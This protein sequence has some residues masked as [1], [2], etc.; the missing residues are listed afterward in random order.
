MADD[1]QFHA[2][3]WH[4][5]D[6]EIE[7]DDDNDDENDNKEHN[8]FQ[9]VK[10]HLVIKT[11]G[12]NASGQ[13]V[14][15]TITGFNPYFYIRSVNPNVK[16]TVGRVLSEICKRVKKAKYEKPLVSLYPARDLMGFQGEKIHD[17]FKISCKEYGY[18]RKIASELA[19]SWS[20]VKIYESNVEPVL[21][22]CH[23][24]DINPAGW[25][26][27]PKGK[28]SRCQ[29]TGG[30]TTSKID[31][32]AVWKD[33]FPLACESVAPVSIASFDIEC[34]GGDEGDFPQAIKGYR[35]LAGQLIAENSQASLTGSKQSVFIRRCLQTAFLDPKDV[36]DPVPG[37]S[38]VFPK[39]TISSKAVQDLINLH[40][41]DIREII[42]QRM[43]VHVKEKR[44]APGIKKPAGYGDPLTDPCRYVLCGMSSG[45]QLKS[46]KDMTRTKEDILRDL[47]VKL[48]FSFPN[49][50]GDKI[51]Q[52]GTTF[53]AYGEQQVSRKHII[54]LNTCD[55]IEGVE[56]VQCETEKDLLLVWSDLIR[57]SDPDVL[58]GY[59]INGFDFAYMR[60][61]AVENNILEQFSKLGK[62]KGLSSNYC[63]ANLTSSALGEN[64]L[65]YFDIEGRVII[66]LM[67]VIQR[68]HKLDTYKL[69]DV[70]FTFLKER[71]NDVSP[72]DI[73]R[74]QLGD[75]ADRKKIAE[76]CVQ[77][78]ALCNRLLIRLETLANNL[79]MASVC[80]VPLQHIFRRGQ[81]IK[82][83]SLML[84]R[85]GAEKLLI[86][87][88]TP[89]P[90]EKYEGAV[91]LD[92]ETGMY[93]DEVVCVMDYNSLYPSSIIAENLSHDSIVLSPEFANLPDVEYNTVI[94][95][96]HTEEDGQKTIAGQRTCRFVKSIRGK[97]YKG[98]VP[99]IL[100]DLLAARKSTRKRATHRTI[101]LDDDTQYSG[102][103]KDHG[104]YYVVS[105]QS[106]E[107]SRV[108]KI[109]DVYDDFQKAV[110]DG[111][112]LAYKITANSI[113]GQMGARTSPVYLKDIAA[114]T[115]AVGRGM[116]HKAKAFMEERYQARV[117]YGDTDS[118]FCIFPSPAVEGTTDKE[119]LL[120]AMDLSDKATFEFNSTITHPQ[121][122]ESE[123]CFYPFCLVS[124]K[125]YIGMLYPQ[126]EPDN[127][128]MKSM[129]LV[130][131][132]RDNAPIVKQ[133][134]GGVIDTILK[135]RNLSKSVDFLDSCLK[136]LVTGEYPIEDLVITKS[137]KSTYADPLRIAHKVL[138]ERIGDRDPGNKPQSSDRIKY[139]FIESTAKL[140]GERIETP[141]FIKEQGLKVDYCFYI[142]NQ[143]MNPICQLYSIVLEQLIQQ[144]NAPH[145]QKEL[146]EACKKVKETYSDPSKAEDRIQTLQE[147]AVEKLLFTPIVKKTLMT[148]NQRMNNDAKHAFVTKW[149][150]KANSTASSSTAHQKMVFDMD[151]LSK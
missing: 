26:R 68:D 103:I 74:L 31:V 82:V 49:L 2:L 144:Q 151:S 120:H 116:I 114:C 55:D 22:F 147:R 86:P 35:K 148:R 111:L 60:D 80:V 42:N 41:D 47:D 127:G 89:G 112:Q 69:D 72:S 107:K 66:D 96:I 45:I 123:K 25:I 99:R 18:T 50:H 124:K 119:K 21:R 109:Q 130:L 32:Q 20:D 125:R 58:T 140:Q 108:T 77:D 128:K 100:E 126:G 14:S 62:I 59:N 146:N 67:K 135:E 75:S 30:F 36:K 134:Y 24:Q 17:F 97:P 40:S 43:Y 65:R 115:T 94:Y 110:L 38:K 4:A 133:I 105:G 56:V 8:Q 51:I 10:K 106:I 9:P 84:K 137:L 16:L 15:L 48:C 93:L 34:M 79:G 132:R 37:I 129:G 138:A 33:V 91:V 11:F 87:T 102:D 12:R 122:L 81:G 118:I 95:D 150:K 78:C 5:V 88:L 61:R 39:N 85:C 121:H 73:F 28:Y 7:E 53:H 145:V 6:V 143:I 90:P 142:T 76:Y 27:V 44:L 131:K 139:V 3:S 83:F 104:D 19:S 13:S 52:I 101:Y 98:I 23:E 136:R 1:L 54:T 46:A 29:G 63:E 57:T 141:E 64:L 149:Y 113:Y 71:K 117:I 70:A 92:P